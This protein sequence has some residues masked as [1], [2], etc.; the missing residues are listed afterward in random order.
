MNKALFYGAVLI[1]TYLLVAH[2]S[3]AGTVLKSAGT[4]GGGVVK[5]LQG[6]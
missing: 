5:A 1:G 3:G 6:R 2:A 4:A